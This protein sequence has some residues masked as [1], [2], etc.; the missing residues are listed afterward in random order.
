MQNVYNYSNGSGIFI[1]IGAGAGDLDSRAN[2]NDGFTH[3]IKNLPRNRIK[4]IILVEPN[5][6]NI[7][8]LK[9]C[10]KD[11]PE[12]IIYQT[13]IVPK[14]IKEKFID[15]YYCTDDA[16][17]YQVASVNKS[18]VQKFY[19]EHYIIE[20][21]SVST[22]H[23]ESFIK[24][25]TNEEIE[26]LALDIEGLDSEILLDLDFN[27]INIKFLSFE[28]LHLGENKDHVLKR[29]K[30][31]SFEFLGYGVDYNSFDYLYKKL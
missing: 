9:E 31:N 14:N 22:K 21:I 17:H 20:K 15:L 18:H 5:P 16:P 2:F 28:Y 23:L 25:I 30:N 19:N 6:L 4:K 7:L 11:Y 8:S 24:E 13:A 29:L 1:Q 26:L 10:W 27:D 12:A 3:F